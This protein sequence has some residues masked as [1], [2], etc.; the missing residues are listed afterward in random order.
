VFIDKKCLNPAD[1]PE[2]RGGHTS[3]NTPGATQYANAILKQYA[4][5][6]FN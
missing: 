4:N 5:E 6:A 2:L 3:V 1:F